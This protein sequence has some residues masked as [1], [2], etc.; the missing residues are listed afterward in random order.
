MINFDKDEEF[1][2]LVKNVKIFDNQDYRFIKKPHDINFSAGK[3]FGN[4]FSLVFT[5]AIQLNQTTASL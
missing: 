2:E 4:F 1:K 3:S 5:K